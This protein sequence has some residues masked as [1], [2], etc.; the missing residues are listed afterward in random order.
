MPV[1]YERREIVTPGDLL[2]EDDYVAGD[3]TYKKDGKIYATRVGLVGYE[4]RK[5]F[6][7]A[8]KSFYVPYVGDLVIGKVVEVGLGSWLIDISAPYPALLRAADAINRPFKP[9][10]DDL[11]SI[12]DVGDL[13]MAKIVAY[14]RTRAPLLTIREPEL[15]KVKRG[16][17]VKITPTKIP[18]VIGRQGSMISMLKRETNCQIIVGQNGVI[19]VSGKSPKD[20]QLVVMAIH[21]IKEEAHTSGLTDRITQMVK[22]EKGSVESA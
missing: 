6:V 9:Q 11:P 4:N 13:V 8:L 19:L 16:Q 12:L 20:E 14:D 21:R 18:R 5:V 2:A 7:V 10:R 1:F 3:N 22:S 15:G 17:I